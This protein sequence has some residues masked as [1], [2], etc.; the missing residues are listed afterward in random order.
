MR[1]LCCCLLHVYSEEQLIIDHV[2]KLTS[3][4]LRLKAYKG[5]KPFALL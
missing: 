4:K 1:Q 5:L 2:L 3:A